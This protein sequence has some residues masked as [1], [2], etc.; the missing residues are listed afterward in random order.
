MNE[1]AVSLDSN[2]ESEFVLLLPAAWA[3]GLAFV[4]ESYLGEDTPEMLERCG[5]TRDDDL[6]LEEEERLLFGPNNLA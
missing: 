5:I 3:Q 4:T 1:R 2:S 6:T